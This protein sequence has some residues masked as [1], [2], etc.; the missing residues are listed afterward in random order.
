V[1]VSTN[2]LPEIS[3]DQLIRNAYWMSGHLEASQ[4]PSAADIGMAMQLLRLVLD[5][6]QA[7]GIVLRTIERSLLTLV[8]GQAQYNLDPDTIDVEVAN[9]GIAGMIVPSTGNGESPVLAIR[10]DEWMQISNKSVDP[11][12]PT[13]VYIE[14]LATVTATFYPPPSSES[15]QFRYRRVRLLRDVDTGAVTT[16]LP[17]RW[18]LALTM[19][20]SALIARAKSLPETRVAALTNDFELAKK[21]VRM[22]DV[23]RGPIRLKL[24]HS[25]KNW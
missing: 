8:N 2:S 25:G 17:S 9:N 5:G 23:E 3:R 20:L 6:L 22:D 7:E 21:R 12:R 18:N 13:L 19:G 10:A 15:A 1:T 4:Q 16:D 24:G 11:S 14:K